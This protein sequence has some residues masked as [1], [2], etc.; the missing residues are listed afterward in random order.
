[1][2]RKYRVT[3]PV[4]ILGQVH[5]FGDVVELDDAVADEV[6]YALIAAEEPPAAARGS[7]RAEETTWQE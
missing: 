1:M 5:E 3:L 7:K 4:M 2:K 6:S